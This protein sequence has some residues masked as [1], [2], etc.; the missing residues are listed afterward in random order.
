MAKKRY[1]VQRSG[2]IRLANAAGS[3]V[4]HGNRLMSRWNKRLYRQSRFY[5]MKIEVDLSDTDPGPITVFAL[6][7]TWGNQKAYQMAFDVYQKTTEEERRRLGSK[8][9]RWQDFTVQSGNASSELLGAVYDHDGTESTLQGGEFN[10]TQ[11]EDKAGNTMT[12][13]WGNAVANSSYS[14]VSEYDL[15][16]DTGDDPSHGLAEVLPYD[17]QL[18]DDSDVER[19]QLV[20]RGN[21]PPYDRDGF[22]SRWEKVAVLRRLPGEQKLSTGYFTAPCGFAVVTGLNASGIT[23]LN[24]EFKAGDYKGINAPSMLE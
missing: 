7:D 1:P 6:R 23:R 21:A 13:T 19:N 15:K 5:Q 16:A 11:V 3:G 24:I 2:V 8:I 18:S 4:V 20:N 10:D 14:I 12:F 17:E 22:G 9:A